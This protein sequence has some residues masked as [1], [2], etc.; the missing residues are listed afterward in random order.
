MT[1]EKPDLSKVRLVPHDPPKPPAPWLRDLIE[2]DVAAKAGRNFE[3][4]EFDQLLPEEA[5]IFDIRP[6]DFPLMISVFHCFEVFTH[7]FISGADWDEHEA[8]IEK[9]RT[10]HPDIVAQGFSLAGFIAFAEVYSSLTAQQAGRMFLKN[11]AHLLRNGHLH[12]LSTKGRHRRLNA[13]L[14]KPSLSLH[15]IIGEK[16]QSN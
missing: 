16:S 11:Q 2:Q 1:E 8:F 5:A 7:S 13:L 14:Q 4:A 6:A 9:A 15:M 3:G 12:F 10:D